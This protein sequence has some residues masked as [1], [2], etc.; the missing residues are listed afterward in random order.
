MP[1]LPR[2]RLFTVDILLP[3]QTHV[4]SKDC[5]PHAVPLS[6]LTWPPVFHSFGDTIKVEVGAVRSATDGP[7][8]PSYTWPSCD[9]CDVCSDLHSTYNQVSQS[10][11]NGDRF[12]TNQTV[13]QQCHY[14]GLFRVAPVLSRVINNDFWPK[15][16]PKHVTSLTSNIISC[17]PTIWYQSGYESM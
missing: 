3:K 13:E 14:L 2:R 16:N 8:T 7:P 5:G 11:T 4:F 12:W 1:Q 15:I 10:S 6:S 9:Y 17:R